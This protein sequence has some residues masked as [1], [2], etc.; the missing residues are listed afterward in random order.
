MAD[1]KAQK[2]EPVEVN[3]AKS[4]A[5][6]PHGFLGRRHGASLGDIAG[7][8]VGYGAD[9]DRAVV[10]RNRAAAAQAIIGDAIESA[11]V[12]PYQVHSADAVIVEEAW[13]EDSRPTADALVTTKPGFLL[14]IVTAD[15]APVLMADREVGVIGAAHAGW[16][17]AHGGVIEA[18]VAAMV[19]CGAQPGNVVA[20]IGPC[21]AQASYEVD[22]KFREQ[23]STGDDQFFATGKSGHFQFDLEAY[24]ASRLQAAGVG[25]IE[26]L[27]LDTYPDA[28]RFYSYRRATHRGEPSYGRQLS[29]IALP[30]VEA[31]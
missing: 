21:I 6:I 14:G 29:A 11:L 2:A 22:E 20:A 9:D 12:T 28:D 25:R 7:L 24:V 10:E 30:R 23:F 5:G 19:S 26:P 31:F 3:Q 4:L 18:T 16:R 15:C 8:N 27:G 13:D 17:G 1:R